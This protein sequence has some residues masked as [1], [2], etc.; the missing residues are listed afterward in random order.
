VFPSPEGKFV[1][2]HNFTN[3]AWKAVLKS[4]NK[5]EHRNAYQTRHTFC[6]L[7]RE[8]DIPS[9]QLAKWVENSAQMIDRV[10]AKPVDR[11]AVPEL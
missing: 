10:Y 1:D 7:C 9:I 6:S 11:I 8:A 3:R 2:W 4:L 5:I